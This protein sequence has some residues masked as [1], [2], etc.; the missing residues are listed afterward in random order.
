MTWVAWTLG[1]GALVVVFVLWDVV[2]CGGKRC[3]DP[4]DR[5]GRWAE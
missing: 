5:V 1:A 4:V 3:R 2:F